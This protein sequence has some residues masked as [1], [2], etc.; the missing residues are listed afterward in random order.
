MT[1]QTQSKTFSTAKL[2][3]IG[4][5]AAVG[6]AL[7]MV[8]FVILP[9]A[10]FYKLDPSGEWLRPDNAA[11]LSGWTVDNMLVL[12]VNNPSSPV[13]DIV[14]EDKNGLSYLPE[15]GYSQMY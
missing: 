9:G 7:S 10:P 4:I 14:Y 8:E 13:L 11:R 2:T 1:A 15:P 3:R 6:V 12:R 5:L